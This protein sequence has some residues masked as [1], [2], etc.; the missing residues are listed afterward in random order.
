MNNK[1]YYE[2]YAKEVFDLYKSFRLAGFDYDDAFELTKIC[3]ANQT[4]DNSFYAELDRK[5]RSDRLKASL[6]NL[7]SCE[8]KEKNHARF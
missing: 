6:N 3:I 8:E 1:Q 2:A 7:K 5:R 4:T